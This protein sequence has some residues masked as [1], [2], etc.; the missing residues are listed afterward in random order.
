MVRVGARLVVVLVGKVVENRFQ[1]S[2]GERKV[3]RCPAEL[4]PSLAPLREELEPHLPLAEPQFTALPHFR[5]TF[6]LW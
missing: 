2:A 1:L 4:R 6:K 3:Q 5:T